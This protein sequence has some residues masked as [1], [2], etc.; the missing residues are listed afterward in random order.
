M[1]N[2]QF[3]IVLNTNYR[4]TNS[5]FNV[6]KK[7]VLTIFVMSVLALSAKADIV[8]DSLG[9]M[10]FTPVLDTNNQPSSLTGIEL[11]Y[12]QKSTNQILPFRI[13]QQNNATW[14]RWM[15]DT[16]FRS[17][18]INTQGQVS[19]GDFH[20][21]I[22]YPN[23]TPRML[24]LHNSTGIGLH[25]EQRNS[26]SAIDVVTNK[27]DS[28]I[29]KGHFSQ[30]SYAPMPFYSLVFYVQGDGLVYSA[31]SQITLSDQNHKREIKTVT[32]ALSGLREVNPVSYLLTNAQTDNAT[33]TASAKSPGRAATTDN[34][35][36]EGEYLP[37]TV[38]NEVLD[39][40]VQAAINAERN[41]PIYGFVAQEIEQIF[42]N[43]VYTLTTGEKAIAYQEI[44]PLLVSALQEQQNMID[45]LVTRVEQLENP[46]VQNRQQAPA[47]LQEAIAD[48]SAALMQNTPNPFNQAT[49]I[50]YRLPEGTATAMI[51][52]CD[53]NGKALQTYPLPVNTTSGKLTIQA[54]SYTPG[55]YLYT[56][57]IDGVQIDTK[58]MIILAH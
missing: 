56:L 37:D 2:R 18:S 7:T 24:T 20:P 58:Q 28:Y 45:S 11:Q 48:G 32:N 21:S 16:T 9:R 41:R 38:V 51:M 8:V 5:N 30:N 57:L 52:L 46:S 33:Y 36:N 43:V 34:V 29:I 19:I 4:L 47:A 50:A 31:R 14:M 40:S 49:E 55:M 27:N 12:F 1:M 23:T 10:T 22:V 3:F 35:Y 42:P 15:S 6:M 39:P 17:F 13:Y 25:I 26:N 44:I 54:G 53:M